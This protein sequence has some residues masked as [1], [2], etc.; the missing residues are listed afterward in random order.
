MFPSIA[1]WPMECSPFIASGVTMLQWPWAY[2]Q[3][4]SPHVHFWSTL[5]IYWICQ[6]VRVHT[7]VC[8]VFT[9]IWEAC[10]LSLQQSVSTDKAEVREESARLKA[11][12]TDHPKIHTCVQQNHM[13]LQGSVRDE[14]GRPSLAWA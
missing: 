2:A 11:F 5:P 8:A 7:C 12:G 4:V 6:L 14:V 10:P 9:V 3:E 1:L 13:P